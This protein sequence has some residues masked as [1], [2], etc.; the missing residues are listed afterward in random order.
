MN[1]SE[2]RKL[3]ARVAAGDLERQQDDPVDLY[4]WI[5]DVAERVLIADGPDEKGNKVSPKKRPM[6][7][8]VAVGLSNKHDGYAELRALIESPLWDFQEMDQDGPVEVTQG[9]LIQQI[10]KEA[11]KLGILEDSDDKKARD[12]VRKLLEDRTLLRAERES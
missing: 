4:A 9:K 1:R 7:V 11:R 8:L 6:R 3:W 2:S 12:L 10:V 5:K